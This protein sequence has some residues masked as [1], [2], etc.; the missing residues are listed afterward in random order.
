MTL[1]ILSDWTENAQHGSGRGQVGRCSADQG[2]Q[3]ASGHQELTTRVYN[4]QTQLEIRKD[5]AAVVDFFQSMF[6]DLGFKSHW[7]SF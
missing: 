2:G 4:G 3:L 7:H 6:D 1:Q 5:E